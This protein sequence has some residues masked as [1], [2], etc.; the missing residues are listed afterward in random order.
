MIR[1][2]DNDAGPRPRVVFYVGA[3]GTAK[4]RESST[5]KS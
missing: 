5:Q 4:T 2:I 3:T 1:Q